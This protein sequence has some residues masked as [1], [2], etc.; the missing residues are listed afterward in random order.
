MA[1]AGKKAVARKTV[2]A[3]PEAKKVRLAFIGYG[4]QART[5]L[6]P[7][8]IKQVTPNKE[9]ISIVANFF[10]VVSMI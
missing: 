8:F 1:N 7:N 3:K 10:L 6:I 9:E 2:K 5:V 4:I